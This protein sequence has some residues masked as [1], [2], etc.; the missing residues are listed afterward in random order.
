MH[1]QSYLCMTL[2][3]VFMNFDKGESVIRGE[4]MSIEQLHNLTFIDINLS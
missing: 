3:M 2:L 1:F 4:Y